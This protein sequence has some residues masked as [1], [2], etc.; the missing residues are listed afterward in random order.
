MD[1]GNWAGNRVSVFLFFLVFSILFFIPYE[2]IK[3]P[4]WG[5]WGLSSFLSRSLSFSSLFS[6]VFP[7][8][9]FPSFSLYLSL[10]LPLSLSTSLSLYLCLSL[11][12]SLSLYT[13]LN[14]S[15]SL[16]LSSLPLSIS[17]PLSLPLSLSLFRNLPFLSVPLF[18]SFY[19]LHCLTILECAS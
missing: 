2:R 9:L 15:T 11:P 1:Q 13:P 5:R 17:L 10:S 16:Y 19:F 18:L 4:G 12:L 3:W 8:S 6:L 7:S 14:L